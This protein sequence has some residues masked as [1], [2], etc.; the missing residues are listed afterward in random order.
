MQKVEKQGSAPL[1]G[2]IASKEE[3][4]LIRPTNLKKIYN[5]NIYCFCNPAEGANILKS[6]N[7]EV[8]EG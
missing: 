7:W 3:E 4:N 8:N 2:G 6:I 5:C 1:K